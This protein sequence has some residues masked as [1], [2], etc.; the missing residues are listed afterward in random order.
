MNIPTRISKNMDIFHE[1]GEQKLIRI[2]AELRDF[3]QIDVNQ[4]L[5][6]KSKKI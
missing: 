4:F 5:N 3:Y 1:K 2:S 6:L